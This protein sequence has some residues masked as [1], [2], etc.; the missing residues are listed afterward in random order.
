MPSYVK[1][2][3]GTTDYAVGYQSV[4]QLRDNLQ[5]LYDAYVAEHSVNEPM[6]SRLGGLAPPPPASFLGHHDTPKIPRAVIRS[7]IF[8]SAYSITLP[9]DTFAQPVV[10]SLSRVQTG[11]FFVSIRGLLEF[12]AEAEAYQSASTSERLVLP[13]TNVG[14]AGT[15]SGIF[16]ECYEK[17]SAGAG[18]IPM[19]FDF[20]AVIYGSTE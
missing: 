3:K 12:Y 17:D 14:G 16:I 13:R 20:S 5:S 4:N 9:G 19:D 10:G 1:L 7:K 8:S 6:P 11:V 18:F 15:P 2:P